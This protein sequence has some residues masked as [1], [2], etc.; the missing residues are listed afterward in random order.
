MQRTGRAQQTPAQP[1]S[2]PVAPATQRGGQAPAS[3]TGAGSMPLP[4]T[5]R[6]NASGTT[7]AGRQASARPAQPTAPTQQV[8]RGATGSQG[9]AGAAGADARVIQQPGQAPRRT[10]V[11]RTPGAVQPQAPEASG[12]QTP[13][14][15]TSTRRPRVPAVPAPVDARP[16]TGVSSAPTRGGSTQ[17][18]FTQGPVAG[19]SLPS[20]TTR[21]EQLPGAGAE[22]TESDSMLSR[23]TR[24][25]RS[26]LPGNEPKGGDEQ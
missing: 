14:R 26:V 5:A 4:G 9:A 1:A 3:R 12:T 6:P 10:R 11:V 23:A 20:Q 19:T 18:S 25:V 15:A 2:S 7:A 22:Q 24:A 17:R 13:T 16:T 8:R 21:D